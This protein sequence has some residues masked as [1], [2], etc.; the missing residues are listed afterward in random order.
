[1]AFEAVALVVGIV[2]L[3]P[4]LVTV[5]FYNRLVTLRNRC[6]E[7]WANV[8]TELKRRYDL[9]PNL[10]ATVEGY[11]KHERGLM[12]QVTALRTQAM[13]N[14]GTP[15]AQ[16]ADERP[17][18]EA[19]KR[20]LAVAEAYPDLKASRNF[21]K[22]QHELAI[23]EDRIQAARRFYNANVRDQRN[24]ARTFPGNL[25]ASWFGFD[26]EDYFQVDPVDTNLPGVQ[27]TTGSGS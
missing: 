9:I 18:V 23:T 4:V 22:L 15:H 10:V 12:E 26:E 5:H 6:H 1:M 27:L 7:S 25:F 3:V 14:H 24:A 11:A 19:L 13:A 16:E 2:L 20:L 21:L 8:D 17:L